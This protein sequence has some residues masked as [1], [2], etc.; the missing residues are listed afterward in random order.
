VSLTAPER[1]TIVTLN[2]EDKT[3]HVYTAQRPVIT[4]LK[5][6]PAATLLEEGTHDGSAWAR[7]ELPKGLIS[8][9]STTV[10]RELTEEQREEL[11]ERMAKAREARVAA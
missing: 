4:K 7:F 5:R 11:R 1:E 10:R 3:A 9:R 6:N 2:D 8:F